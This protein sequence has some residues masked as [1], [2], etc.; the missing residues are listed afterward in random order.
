MISIAPF[1]T[2]IL[3]LPAC[4]TS[5]ALQESQP[6]SLAQS[7]ARSP[8]AMIAI[9]PAVD[10]REAYDVL[11]Y[12][13]DLHL[14]PVQKQLSG[15]VVV[16]AKVVASSMDVLQLDLRNELN[17]ESVEYNGAA[18]EYAHT[19]DALLCQ[20]PGPLAK[21]EELSVAVTYSG[22]PTAQDNFSGF[23]WT[24]TADG[25]PW[26][27]TSCQGPGAHSWWP[28]KASFYHPED[29]PERITIA[30][31]LAKPLYAVSNGRLETIEDLGQERKF[32]WQ[33]DYPIE[34]YSVTLNAAPYV[35]V[36]QKLDLEG[37][38]APLE[39]DY[40][41]L[42]ENA[43]KA[44]LQFQQVPELIQIYSDAFG[45]F[46]FPK[47]KFGLVETNFWGME[48]STAVAYGSSYPAWCKAMGEKDVYARRN[49]FFDYILIHEVAHEWWG[50]AVSATAWGHFWIHEGFGTYAEGIYVERTAGRERADEYFAGQQRFAIAAGEDS[51]LYRG[52]DVDSEAAYAGVIY[53]KGAS[54]LNT[55]RVYM[56]DDE[57]WWKAIREFNLRFRYGNASSDDFRAVLEEL[58]GWS[59]ES[60]FDSWVY[61][62]GYPIVSGSIQAGPDSIEVKLS[63]VGSGQTSFELPMDLEWSEAGQLRR[64]R[65]MVKPGSFTASISCES[66][67]HDL[68]VMH[69]DRV[70]GKHE[71][72]VN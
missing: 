10:L 3:V 47:S 37:Y 38:D 67:P 65:L 64:T 21:A 29:K 71:I 35:V 18:I 52:A 12:Q 45:P 68:R 32:V 1:L 50:N 54:V 15:T 42:P 23:H 24:Q 26:I 70:L 72:E 6:S 49:Q 57:L 16:R 17:V 43:E 55:M 33:H 62:E 66:E 28:C 27:N 51:R 19:N 36:Q 59:W 9:D 8:A 39:F 48:H 40:Y 5:S 22:Y 44:A 56:G 11:E 69:F 30:I 4:A 25:S 60:I 41:V 31:T 53:S 34:T 61:G 63:N 2:A 46:P 20:L 7:Q 14:D 13:L 58:S